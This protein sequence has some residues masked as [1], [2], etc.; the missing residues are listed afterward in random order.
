MTRSTI[1]IASGALAALALSLGACAPDRIVTG[2]TYPMDYR[3]RHPIVIAN[4][5]ETLDLFV[6]GGGLD[7]RQQ[8]ELYAFAQEYRQHGQGFVTAS[9]PAGARAGAAGKRALAS[10]HAVLARAG[11]PGGQVIVTSHSV[12][13]PAL[14]TPVRLSFQRLQAKVGSRCGLWPQDLG[15]SDVRANVNNQPYWNL[16]CAMQSNVAAQVDDPLDLVRARP[17]GRGD[18]V[19]RTAAIEKLRKGQDP[20]TQYS[21]PKDRINQTIG[22]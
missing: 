17:E 2:S 22:D 1:K 21:I 9:V 7:G 6:A 14:A 3:D 15:V 10:V 13:E 8:E 5:P 20:S 19:R 16:G 4:A 18:T 12:V 11:V